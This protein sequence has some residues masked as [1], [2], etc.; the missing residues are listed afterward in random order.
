[1]RFLLCCTLILILGPSSPAAHNES[2]KPNTLTPQEIADGW[3]LL[4]DGETTYGWTSEGHVKVSDGTLAI[5]GGN[6]PTARP[7]SPFGSFDL[8]FECMGSGQF[9]TAVQ[10][11]RASSAIGD[12]VWQT[13]DLEMRDDPAK[14][15]LSTSMIGG[16]TRKGSVTYPPGQLTIQ[17]KGTETLALRNVKIKPV[18]LKAIFNGKDL[19]GWQAIPGHKSKFNVNEKGELNIKDGNGDIQ[20]EGQWDDFVL[21]LDVFSNGPHLNS[22]VFF[23]A[24][25][26]EF[27]S[28]YEAQIRNEW[29]SDVV[30]KDGTKFTGSYTP[31][32]DEASVQVYAKKNGRWQATKEK[33]S[34]AKS[35]V[36]EVI[37]HR[38][39][40]IDFGTGAI[41]NRQAA[42][43]VVSNDYE[44]YTMTVAAQGNHIATWVNGYQVT[45]FTDTR[46]SNKSARN[47]SKVDKGPISL[48]GH[49]PTTDLNFRNIRIAEL[50]KK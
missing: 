8:H 4:F 5:S 15:G 43:K 35:D 25:P 31:K 27:W 32:G 19:T 42:R 46:P 13:V 10:S 39:Q 6:E 20:T 18:G 21:Q 33:K 44:W 29:I 40:P 37:D 45:D 36:R 26:G 41:Y 16:K 2:S 28:G 14:N 48:Q 34:F 3:I 24:L 22:G 11:A 30:L 9:V 38:D 47:G 17:F 7:N 12:Q 49:D 23:R 50:P 1:M